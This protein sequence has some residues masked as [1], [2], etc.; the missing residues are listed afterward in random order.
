MND[1]DSKAFLAEM[2]RIYPKHKDN[3]GAVSNLIV[4]L[5]EEL[6][7]ERKGRKRG[8]KFEGEWGKLV[9]LNSKYWQM[10]EECKKDIAR[11]SIENWKV[12]AERFVLEMNKLEQKYFPSK[13]SDNF[14]EKVMEKINKE[15]DNETF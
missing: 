10:W 4:L 14:T 9:D 8:E 7:K 5:M 15:A 11:A 2:A 1:N 12:S 6:Q 13:P 3:F